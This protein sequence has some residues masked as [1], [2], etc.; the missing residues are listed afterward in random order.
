MAEM[1]QE[2]IYTWLDLSIRNVY[3]SWLL[4]TM[5]VL[6]DLYTWNVAF[7]FFF[8]NLDVRITK[9]FMLVGWE[10]VLEISTSMRVCMK[11]FCFDIVYV[12]FV[13]LY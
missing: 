12:E 6:L 11:L 13:I 8:S 9:H 3:A 10:V 7:F 1:R 2:I 5:S 4:L